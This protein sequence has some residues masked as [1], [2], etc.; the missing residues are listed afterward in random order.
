MSVMTRCASTSCT[1]ANMNTQTDMSILSGI[2]VQ[3]CVDRGFSPAGMAMPTT[4]EALSTASNDA[5]STQTAVETGSGS[6]T[7][8]TSG[9]SATS[10]GKSICLIYDFYNATRKSD[11]NWF[12]SILLFHISL[13]GHSFSDISQTLSSLLLPLLNPHQATL[14]PLPKPLVCLFVRSSLLL[15]P[16]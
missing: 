1:F 9:P 5:F 13:S 4:V 10:G 11:L 14:L 3:Y 6:R 12:D 15:R 7:R 8:P 16:C 2:Q